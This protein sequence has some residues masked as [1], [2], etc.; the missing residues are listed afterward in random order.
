[1]RILHIDTELTWR[2][3]EN[4]LRLLLAGLAKAGA[5]SFIAVRPGS[6][7]ATRLTPLGQVATLPM[8]GGFDPGAALALRRLCRDH[9]ID[10]ID[11]HTSNAHSLAL[12]ATLGAPRVRLVVHRRVDYVPSSGLLNRRKYLTPRVDRYV[13]ISAAIKGVLTAYGVPEG[14]VAVVKSAIDTSGYHDSARPSARAAL[15]QAY[16]V[17]PAVAFLGNASALTAQKG[18]EVLIDAAAELKNRGVPFHLF[19][20]GEGELTSKLERQRADLGLEHH[21]TFLGFIQDV[22]GFLSGLDVLAVPSNY[23]GLGTIILEG[24]GAGLPVVATRVGGIPEII[25]H[26][27][28]GLLSDVGDAHQL[29]ANLA[30]AIGDPELRRRLNEAARAHVAREFSV[31]AMSC[32]RKAPK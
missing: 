4:Q 27:K 2:G 21:V 24:T 8:R 5:E 29:A 10:V 9:A 20:A 15:A 31:D 1:V 7:A 28:T 22:P 26:G 17:D 30:L 14:R 12:L 3:G 11:A 6:A 16:G 18:Y 19:I 25:T 13:A 23:E 32:K